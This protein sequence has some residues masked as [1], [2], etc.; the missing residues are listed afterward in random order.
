MGRS[1]YVYIHRKA[2]TGEIFYVGKGTGRRAY[3]K[4]LRTKY[5]KRTAKKHGVVVDFVIKDVQEWYALELEELLVDYYGRK[6]LNTGCLVN[7][8]DGGKASTTLS[9]ESKDRIR[10]SRIGKGLSAE[11]KAKLSEAHKGRTFSEEHLKKLSD[12]GKQRG[13]SEEIRQA[14]VNK[15][16]KK[17]ER[18]DGMTFKSSREAARYIRK[19]GIY[20]KAGHTNIS[21][22]ALGKVPKAYGFTWK[23]V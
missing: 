15:L 3:E 20:V 23:Y 16:S 22:A 8:C 14:L 9:E 19:E 13:I 10:K 5:W 21:A 12:R 11:T 17:I 7:M 2:T 4:N 1:Y 18:S 6:D